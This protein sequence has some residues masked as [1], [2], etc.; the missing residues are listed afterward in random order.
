MAAQF[1]QGEVTRSQEYRT[2][3]SN[4]FGLQFL[5]PDVIIR[6]AILKDGANPSVGVDE[7]CGIAMS[8]VAAK[9]LMLTLKAMIDQAESTGQSIPVSQE[10]HDVIKKIAED[11]RK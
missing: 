8:S 2:F 11:K 4:T 5:G 1:F 6:C 7:Q 10:V 3:Y 9:A